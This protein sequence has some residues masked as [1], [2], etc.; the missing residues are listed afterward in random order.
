MKTIQI[1]SLTS[2]G[3]LLFSEGAQTREGY[4]EGI[5]ISTSVS[6]RFALRNILFKNVECSLAKGGKIRCKDTAFLNEI[7]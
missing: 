2:T 4:F 5:S 6:S 1:F 3:T 7:L